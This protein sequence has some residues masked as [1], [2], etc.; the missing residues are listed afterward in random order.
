MIYL[1]VDVYKNL[2]KNCLSVKSMEP[3]DR[4]G[5]VISHEQK[6]HLTDVEFVVQQ[7]GQKRARETGTRNVHAFVRGE[8]DESEKV[9]CGEAIRYNPFTEG[10]FEH[11][12]S[13]K[14]V[15]SAKKCMVSAKRISATDISFKQP[16]PL[17]Q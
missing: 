13:G 9:I 8:W 11:K 14:V 7:S 17:L 3:G 5:R 6:V 12:P 4:Y 16:E 2:N 10:G 1:R 15:K